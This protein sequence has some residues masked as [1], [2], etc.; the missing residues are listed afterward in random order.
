MKKASIIYKLLWF[1][2]F[3]LML[4]SIA[5]NPFANTSAGDS[6]AF[7]YIGR[8]WCE[9][10]IPYRDYFDHK[11]PMIFFLNMLGQLP[12]HYYLFLW[13]I[14]CV[15]A[16]T[17][18]F[19]IYKFVKR[20]FDNI[21]PLVVELPVAALFWSFLSSCYG[22]M[23]ESYA[24]VFI[25]Y[26]L[27][28]LLAHIIMGID[29][30]REEAFL[31]GCAFMS[32][33]L[34]RANMVVVAF[35]VAVFYIHNYIA[36]RNWR[37]FLEAGILT[38]LGMAVILVPYVIYFYCKDALYD[39]WYA[40]ILFNLKYAGQKWHWTWCFYPV[41]VA[42]ALNIWLWVIEKEARYR[43]ALAYNLIFCVLTALVLL[44]QPFYPHYFVVFVPGIVL[45]IA[46]VLKHLHDFQM[47]AYTMVML[48][49]YAVLVLALL[50]AN[51]DLGGYMRHV[52]MGGNVAD[53]LEYKEG[54]QFSNAKP[55]LELIENRSS[56]F[57]YGPIGTLYQY[58]GCSGKFK[59]FAHTIGEAHIYDPEIKL[60]LIRHVQESIDRYVISTEGDGE[61]DV[62]DII[63]SNYTLLRK[64]NKYLLWERKRVADEADRGSLINMD[65]SGG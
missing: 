60:A 3:G 29:V 36:T 38:F 32:I 39:M 42:L 7:S 27:L 59:Y 44:K 23:N 33:F 5:T 14:E 9:G 57:V 56:V 65:M 64:S 1:I 11:G 40:S 45:P 4:F 63:N 30:G 31:Y 50:G 16:L 15:F 62:L 26:V 52:R 19:L 49:S 53:I 58:L 55:L 43:K 20:H 8:R 12:G 37:A 46:M 6:A 54:A 2:F 17:G 25:T 10:F 48:P 41:L 13:L 61:P 35:V 51:L 28:S 21:N 34:F 22:N 18:I 47:V 24:F